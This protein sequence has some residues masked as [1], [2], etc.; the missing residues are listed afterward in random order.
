M[1]DQF[2]P[3]WAA[4]KS[5]GQPCPPAEGH[6]PGTLF[7]FPLRQS[8][9]KISENLY[10]PERVQELLLT[11]L[12]DAPISLLFLKNVRRLTLGL[13]GSDGTINEL[14]RAEASTCRLDRGQGVDS[15]LDT[16]A[17]TTTLALCG[18][19][20]G[21]ASS[22]DWLV[23][24]AEAKKEAFQ[25]LWDLTASISSEPVLSLAYP[26]QGS[27][28]G[29]L[30][31]V[32]PLPATEENNTG[33][34]LHISAP[35]QLTDDRRHVQ[36]SE[37]GSQA[38]GADGRWNH[39]LTEE[40]LPVAYCQLVV[41]T[42][43]YRSNPY[44]AWPD[45][46]QCQQLRYKALVARICQGLV[47][48]KLLVPV[49]D[50]SL[51][52]L[53]SQEAVILPEKVI[54]KPVGLALE[55]AL[56]LAGSPLAVAPPH[57]RRALALGT[58]GGKA[59]QEA[60]TKFVRETLRQAGHIWSRVS[61]LEK[62]L[63][64]EYVVED[65]RYQ[66]L[67]ELP[68]LPTASGQFARFGDSGE[69]V[70]V[71]NSTFPRIL[72]PGLAH[73]FLPKDL[74]PTLLQHL[75][76]IAD[77]GLF[78]NLVSLDQAVIEQS[79]R[80]SLPSDWVGSNSA[81]VVWCPKEDPKQPPLEWLAAFWTFLSR[82][83]ASLAPFKGCPLIP[84]T[85][86][87]GSHGG[88]RLARLLPQTSLV[89]QSG[90]RCQLS[91]EMVGILE[92]LGCTVIRS[93][94]P[95]WCHRQLKEF[96]L[97]PTP[98][99]VLQ[100]FANLGVAPVVNRLAS[101][102][103]HRIETL[104]TFLSSAAS[105]SSAETAVLAALPLFFKMPSLLPPCKPALVPAQGCLA[106]EKSLFPPV[107]TDL[108]TPEPVLLCRS[109]SERRLLLLLQK[110]L[111]GAPDLCLLCVKAM[112][113]KAYAGRPQ[114]AKRLMLW[115]LRK[116]DALF[117]Q[118]KELQA[119]CCDLPFLDCG[120]GGLARPR[121][122]Y[123]PE[124]PVLQALLRPD[125]FPIESFREPAVLR[126]LRTLGLKS[127]LGSVSPADVLTAA[128]DVNRLQDAAV[129]S[130]KSQAL[131][132]VCNQTPLLSR[133]ASQELRQL[134]TLAW[135]PATNS[136]VLV[137]AKR[138]LAPESL[139]SEK[140]A[141]LVGLVMGLTN[142]FHLQAAKVLGLER[143]PP[144]EKVL[145]NLALL[146]QKHRPEGTPAA[147]ASLHG[148]YQHMQQHLRDFQDPPEGAVVWNG[149]GFSLPVDIVL[150]YPDGLD[151]AALMPRVPPN[152]QHYS[153]LF[154]AWGVRQ[155][156]D[157]EEL[158]QALCKLADQINARPQGGTQTELC[159]VVAALDWLRV[160][161]HSEL[162]EMVVPVR[163]PGSAGFALRPASSVLY[164]DMD[165]SRLAELDGDPP[166]LVHEAV[167][168][169]TA[170]FLGVEMLSRRLSGLEL[171]EAWGPSEP[172]TLRIRNVL[173]EYSQSP[174]MFLELLQNAEDAGAQTC[175][176][177]VDLRQP[178]GSTKGLLDPGMAACQGPAL[179]AYNDALFSETDF[180]NIIRLGAATK[181][182]LDDKIGRFG[183]GFCTVYHMTDV[184]SLLSGR[185]LLFFDP[186]VT[187]LRKHIRSAAQPGIRLKWT[188]QVVT[189]F[190][191]QFQPYL[192]I[193][194]CQAGEDYQGT[195]IR[196]PFR[197]EQEAKDSEICPEPFGPNRI[198]ALQV[199]F[200]KMYQYLLIFLR[201]VQEVSLAQLPGDATS[202]KAAQPLATV[203]RHV[204]DSS[205]NIV[206][207]TA[208]WKSEVMIS[209]YLL[210]SCSGKGEALRLFQQGGKEGAHF[211]SPDAGVALPLRPATA[212]GRWTPDLD[213]FK[214]RVFCFLPLPIESGLPLHLTAAFA[215]LSNRKGLWDATEKGRWNKA[216]LQDSVLGA[217][218]GALAQLRDMSKEGLLEGYEY[219]T[220]WPV[221]SVAMYP[222]SETAKA[223]YQAL[224][225]G[226]DGE[227]PVL[228]SDGQ[229]WCS[230]QHACILDA[231]V[232]CDK[233]L[234]DVAARVFSSLL[235]EP[236]MAVSVPLWVKMS[237]KASCQEDV[238][239]P[240][241][242]NWER[243][244]QE[245]VLPNLAWLN[246]DDSDALVLRALDMNNANVD[247][248]LT[249]VPCIPT[250][251]NKQLKNI[252]GLVHPKGRIAPL[253]APEDGRFPV[254]D[255]F[256]KPE[257]LLR[258]EHL[259]MSKDQVVMG[260]LIAR[261]Q[262]V[263]PLWHRSQDKACQRVLCILNLLDDHL[264]G[265]SSN[266]A[267]A[268][269]GDIPFLPA[270]LPGNH[271]K[272]CRP[273]EVYHYKLQPLVGLTQPIL[274]KK[275]FG[276]GLKLSKEVMEFLGL[277][278]PPP[279]ATVLGQLEAASHSSNALSRAD[280]AKMTQKCYAFLNDMVK[281]NPSCKTEVSQRA[282]TFPF[283]LVESGFVSVSCVA[284]DLTFDAAPYLF[285]LPPEYQEQKE[286][287][288][289]VGLPHA[290]SM[291]DY[292]T[293]LQALA[294][295][296]AGQPL[297][298]RELDLV[299]RLVNVGLLDVLLDQELE[300]YEAQGIFFPDQD[301]VLRPLPKLHF[302]D[303]PWMPREKS[304]L[305]C[306]PLILREVAIRCDI[307][308]TKHRILSR[309]RIHNVSPWGVD[310]G[311]KEK[312]STRLANIL[313]DYSSSSR[314]V[315]KE[316]LQ[317]ADDAGASVVHFLWDLRHHATSRV[318]SD[319]WAALQGPAFCVYNDRVFQKSDIEGIQ[320]LGCGG[321]GGRHDATG[322][323]GLGFNTV[324]H[325]T[326]CPAFVTGNST[327]CIFDSTLRY[328]P[329]SDE[330]SPGMMYSLSKDFRN[331]FQDV[332]DTF[333]PEVF[334]LEH[335][336]LFRL[337][338]RTPVA[339]A[340][341][342]IC[343]RSVSRE[344]MDSMVL[345]LK[346]EG[347]LFVMFLNH[348]RSVVFSV[349]GEK[350]GAPVE[351]LKIDSEGGGPKKLKFQKQLSQA[352]AAGGMGK[353]QPVRVFYE[354]K[355]KHSSA[356]TPS[357]WLVGKQIGLE[358]TETVEG[359]MLPHGGV[360][361][362]LNKRP[363]GRAFCTLP[364]PTATGLPIHINGNFAVDSARRDLRKDEGAR[365]TAW[366][367]ALLRCL[368]A[369]LYCALLEELRQALG[370]SPLK[371]H[372][373]RACEERLDSKYL[374][375]FPRVTET[376]PPTW[377]QVV[378][379]VYGLMCER[380]RPVVP[381]YQK[382]SHVKDRH[383]EE[384]VSV[385]WSAPKLGHP[386]REPY[387][388]QSSI[389]DPLECT[390]QN[391][392]MCLVPAF[393]RLPLINSEAPNL[394]EGLPLLLTRDNVLRHFSK[395]DPVYQ[396]SA[397]HLF[398][399][400]QDRFFAC[401]NDHLNAR[402]LLLN[403]GF[404]VDFTLCE[405]AAYIKEMLTRKGWVSSPEGS[406]W[407]GKVW[408]FFEEQIFKSEEQD[409]REQAFA[410]L[411]SLFRDCSLLPVSGCS[412]SLVPLALLS[413]IVDSS[414]DEI[415]KILCKLG[416]AML[417]SRLLPV[418]LTVYFI[419]P[420][421][422]QT[423]D[424]SAVLEQVATRSSLDWQTLKPL[425]FTM[426][427]RFLSKDLWKRK[428]DHGWLGKLKSLPVFETHQGK[429]VALSSY[430]NVCILESRISKES[431][432]FKE[433]Y[434]VDKKTVMLKDSELNRDLSEC[435]NIGIMN[436]LQQFVQQVLPRLPHLPEDRQLE[437]VKL[438]LTI[439]NCYK[440]EY[441]EQK[442]TVISKFQSLAFIRDW[443]G[444]L[445]PASYFYDEE[446]SLCQLLKLD[447]R[448]VPEEFYKAMLPTPK[449]K[450]K[451]FLRDVGLQEEIS[452]EDF[453]ACA[454]H[455][456]RE[457]LR[458]G[459]TSGDLP[460]RRKALWKHLL[461]RPNETLSKAFL[462][463]VSKLRFLV[464]QPIP[465]RLCDLHS[466]YSS[467]NDPVAPR[468]SLC[469]EKM[470]ELFWTSGMSL[471]PVG[472]VSEDKDAILTRLGV[473]R[474]LQVD[475]VLK[476]LSNVCQ[477]PCRTLDAKSTRKDVIMLMYGYL[478]SQ[479]DIQIGSLKDCPVVLV[480]GDDLVEAQNVVTSLKY[481]I[482]FR[483]YLYKL[484]PELGTHLNLLKKFGVEE[485]PSIHHYA[486]VL[487]RIH[488]E[489]LEKVTLQA[490]LRSTVLR[491]T[492]FLFQL[493][494]DE[495]TPVDLSELKELYLPCDDG[496]LYRSD[497][498]VFNS[499]ISGQLLED[500]HDTFG[501]LVDLST[502]HLP[503]D[504][505]Q[506]WE[507]LCRL[508]AA[509]RPKKLSD[510]IEDQLES[511]SL[512]LC[513]Y[514]EHCEFQNRLKG[515][516]ISPEFQE[517]LVALLKWQS[518]SK[519]KAEEA[520]KSGG[521][522][523]FSPEKLEVVCCEKVCTV[524]VHNS[525]CLEGTQCAKTVH[526][527]TGSDGKRRIYLLHQENMDAVQT[528]DIATCLA[529]EVNKTLG[530]KLQERAKEV[531]MQILV[532]QRPEKIAKVLESKKVPLQWSTN[533]DAFTLPPPGEDI[534]EEWYDSLDMS[535]LH[536]FVPGDFVGFLAS[537]LPEEHYIYAVVLEALGP[538][539]SGAGQ[540]LAYRV[541]LGGGRQVEVSAY[542]LYHFRRSSPV[543]DSKK[544]MVL[545]QGSPRGA[546]T[547]SP[548]I[549]N[550]Y[551]RPLSEVKKEVD[552]SLVEIWSM[553][554]E[555]RKKALRRLYLCYHPDKNLDQQESA[556][557]IFKYLREKIKEME[558]KAMPKSFSR[559]SKSRDSGNRNFWTFSSSWAEW[560]QQAHWH[561]QSRRAFTGQ[562]QH[563]R[564]GSGGG[565]HFN[566][567]FWTFHQA[568]PKHD[569]RQ[570]LEEAKRWLRQAECDLRAAVGSAGNNSTEWLLYKTYRAIEK[571]LTAVM[572]SEGGSFEKDLPLA[573]LAYNAASY[574]PEL[575]RLPDQVA[576]LRQHG[577]DD[578]MTQYP[579]YHSSPTIPNEAFS[580][581]KEQAVLLLAQEILNTVKNW[582]GH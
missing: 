541:D 395:N 491:A 148:I 472:Y 272:L 184:P 282:Q 172:I 237:F 218:L 556:N 500:L 264:Q 333:L 37:E 145:E 329:D 193:F 246:V 410:K 214:G 186:N 210:H 519:I 564:G 83:A 96:I 166:T 552:A 531:L 507:L 146:A 34:P 92:T 135:V 387:F 231:D 421:L 326:D 371:F 565:G 518:G 137:P 144:P 342:P 464:P 201:S 230:A 423:V 117:S 396:S 455:V 493:L 345:A 385:C 251:P 546:T 370:N 248:I 75:Q 104:S 457:A 380:Q 332:Y 382:Q 185:S 579:S 390:L 563:G 530:E 512:E 340:S 418:R 242:Y 580:A 82:Q 411:V 128:Q 64:L 221:V 153:L 489:T 147:I 167:P 244:L 278:R 263:E 305:L 427:L 412:K 241:T 151:L 337:P 124:I 27:C 108:L 316:L 194:K 17:A 254:G 357:K 553:S 72:L 19:A 561:Q 159:L 544:A 275:A 509:L 400:H 435:L 338:L 155:S 216:L 466:P 506:Q 471:P 63:L 261:A 393:Q 429:Y 274:D 154:A 30:S 482:C 349:I 114:D 156:P 196:L 354:M 78:G 432:Y 181:E 12:G 271:R 15:K 448:F 300:S 203:N 369:P 6:F 134:R 539:Q 570:C 496:K 24:S 533:R 487:A 391:L 20:I 243:F 409:M 211:S 65:G 192:G 444:V 259:G 62:H 45:P 199:G 175:R 292:A 220:F 462:E 404:L 473:Q 286:L 115:V 60:T 229:K 452:E 359:M 13:V 458:K 133:F 89:F 94:Q 279:I 302:D 532:C 42:S 306:H 71:E 363:P 232:I 35:F 461:S 40:L 73:R 551:E 11:F 183:L 567:D 474:T 111:L 428:G 529:T 469:I 341:S 534:P 503:F 202:P 575:A 543:S 28:T 99:C 36:W 200:L 574:G 297:S 90:D 367:S 235:P 402:M 419:S 364:L 168:L 558:N 447:L 368:V 121:E 86:L 158:C 490:N 74:S 113:A 180:S 48:M 480:D 540:V 198:Q 376:V 44:G 344:D 150:A 311:A 226:I 484:P 38:R 29:R 453:L 123:N 206:Q 366:N 501:F 426:L 77:K 97:G 324:Y 197:T 339:A 365:E 415:A 152:F 160:G 550:W 526:A 454:A 422:L 542:D 477:A 57:V 222:F 523:P 161:N 291:Q 392:G 362:C 189:M 26:L 549:G 527:E 22:C 442:E 470:V 511:S 164:C 358:S 169:A 236:Q 413:S 98:G 554:E 224:I 240:N 277:S 9:S 296:A 190:P 373:L 414:V 505:Y 127:D 299:L 131:I 173:R 14:L 560:D 301:R 225:K 374:R 116:G 322:K 520:T 399:H 182:H 4:L 450:V 95:D 267:Q 88:I 582:F 262:T 307:P 126:T 303:T 8:P 372:T 336:T 321:K 424:P 437:A 525:Q 120:S 346:E 347:D 50:G 270:L 571:A 122:L 266:T 578:K 517:A 256:L 260:E 21:R 468:G 384:V 238:L 268:A 343:Q 284:Q 5:L 443:Q 207:L 16:V 320:Q 566:Y 350:G 408:K 537:S 177:L 102:P 577:V 2:Q 353:G 394:L 381:V 157:E 217:W 308:T 174:D 485:E 281:K 439:R 93:W 327:L 323:Y 140:H 239:L 234:R 486:R 219:H 269:F 56:K 420:R 555:E 521:S 130:A 110:R 119:L 351:V 431:K 568:G 287:W 171:F 407:L 70:F 289:C 545:V 69:T 569:S 212:P 499:H 313:R 576:K 31:C 80:S 112:K 170:A 208:T 465:D 334:D 502:C 397:Y 360:A 103:A 557:E 497:T 379:R 451:S 514:G 81:T 425:D 572:Y 33:L 32:L 434:E 356:I 209:H 101:L 547:A 319:E 445:R 87:H 105:F 276:D 7:R 76:I 492:Q 513:L 433:L 23:L 273:N 355:I 389:N 535:I 100:A 498:L 516:L 436:D 467:C 348:V 179:W 253:Y 438:L 475:L 178:D 136:S 528:V 41:L 536:T 494:E 250:T 294:E 227:Q 515:L 331:T 377:H 548:S 280:L 106:L 559:G 191:D 383:R 247:L 315:L 85:S 298:K 504:K 107:P 488:E 479:K 25:E 195:L 53:H 388:L 3:F 538:R 314:D 401:F 456:E 257:R 562:R 318:L 39:L 163:I 132:Q 143:P 51:S 463:K 233:Q 508:P 522:R 459:A 1:P 118:N 375:Y 510:I 54:G 18:S 398:P 283:V 84:L 67:K 416:F 125:R 309:H 495:E 162:R 68:L 204:L 188:H 335:G 91:D 129:A 109:E 328:L 43:G 149:S 285:Q 483:P 449:R 10:S 252:K 79:L 215:V 223:F 265:S 187:H 460:K 255:G 213:Y 55:K 46:E 165:Q 249:S 446:D 310:F 61:P 245:L 573:S 481:P 290:F 138:F 205:P 386:T 403:M 141:A 430:Q 476:N 228:F 58:K 142:A 405:S 440:Q 304:T 417:D 52:L 295:N 352:A 47:G 378:N 317:N 441:K 293:V 49:G 361:A 330:H 288:D 312:L 478:S 258:L 325:L 406:L 66:A 59:V 581:N 176:F 524:M 139:R